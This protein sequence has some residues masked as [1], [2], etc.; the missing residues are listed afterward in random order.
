M[1]EMISRRR[2]NEK[3]AEHIG[4]ESEALDLLIAE[5]NSMVTMSSVVWTLASASLRSLKEL[6][7]DVGETVRVE[8][9]NPVLTRIWEFVK[10]SVRGVRVFVVNRVCYCI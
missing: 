7:T 8:D 6:G 1:M 10:P 9:M 3:T 2:K 5:R 4:P